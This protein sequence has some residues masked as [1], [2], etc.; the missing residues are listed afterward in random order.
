MVRFQAL[1]PLFSARV[2]VLAPLL[3]VGC[4]GES[5]GQP[6]ERWERLWLDHEPAAFHLDETTW[7]GV[8]AQGFGVRLDEA[9]EGVW[10]D[11]ELEPDGWKA[12]DWPRIWRVPR[13]VGGGVM[14][15]QEDSA[16]LQG[17][18]SSYRHSAGLGSLEDI[19]QFSAGEFTVFGSFVYVSSESG[20]APSEALTLS[21]HRQRSR[22]GKPL[23]GGVVGPGFAVWPG[24]RESVACAIGAGRALRFATVVKGMGAGAGTGTGTEKGV[25]FR[26]LL[27]DQLLWEARQDVREEAQGIWRRVELPATER[28]ELSFEVRGQPAITAFLVPTIGPAEVGGYEGRPWPAARPDIVLFLADTFRADNLAIYGGD[29]ALAPNLNALADESVRFRRAWSPSSWTLP[30]QASMLTGLHPEQHGAVSA[31]T[32]IP[33]SLATLT[34]R[35][36]EFGYRTGA[37][38]DS[39]FVSANYGFDQGFEW[40]QEYKEWDLRKTLARATEFLAADDGRP[41]FLFVQT[42]RT[43]SPYRSGID[44]SRAALRELADD[45]RARCAEYGGSGEMSL[46]EATAGVRAIYDDG[47]SSLDRLFGG[48]LADV[49]ARNVLANGYLV[50]TSDH[51][52]EFGEHDR[53]GH[54][55]AISWEPKTRVPLLITGAGLE[56]RDVSEAATL[57]DFPVTL[58]TLAGIPP[59]AGWD[60]RDV[61]SLSEDRAAFAFIRVDDE[62]SVAIVSGKRKVYGWADTRER[63]PSRLYGACDLEELPGED[64]NQ[65]DEVD[66]AEELWKQAHPR[67]LELL[68]PRADARRVHLSEEERAEL[69]A[70]GYG[71]E[72]D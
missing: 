16:R 40:F 57:V 68:Q 55:G 53:I 18:E 6:G 56:P 67:L 24:Q 49:R 47:V 61:L 59:A 58:A 25:S 50:F 19:G 44:E 3:V 12:T 13:P 29:P 7:S 1:K 42:Y 64:R 26:V 27:D 69:A 41:V 65:M 14:T 23:V 37:V 62:T 15:A 43:H 28:G 45:V 46:A 63:A 38:T 70:I 9:G 71:G 34:E 4:G 22:G 5:P 48:W 66:W 51:G 33:S 11:Y 20:G 31:S 36:A 17:A 32:G 60:G 54:G 52:E 8:G 2:F 21:F 72:F 35:L 30:A 39:A 10:F